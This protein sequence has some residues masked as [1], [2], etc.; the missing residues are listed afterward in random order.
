MKADAIIN[1]PTIR[2]TKAIT[3]GWRL[4]KKL[5]RKINHIFIKIEFKSLNVR[6]N[7][8]NKGSFKTRPHSRSYSPLQSNNQNFSNHNVR[9]ESKNKLNNSGT[10][11]GIIN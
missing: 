2:A 10:S 4:F 5:I 11:I 9:I 7:K 8:I 1:T 6:F 3:L